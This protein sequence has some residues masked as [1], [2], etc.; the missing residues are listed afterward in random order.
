MAEGE[1][2]VL[3]FVGAPAA[4]KTEAAS[5]AMEMGIPVITMGDVI[6]GELR[7]RGL[8]LSDENAGRIANE[9]R[10]REGMDAIAKRCIPLIKGVKDVEEKKA[11]KV[12]VIDGIRGIAEVETFKKE[13]GTDFVLVRIDAPLILRYERIK[14]RGRGDDLL[15]IEE[16]KERE[17]RE[18]RWGMG[19]AMKKADKVVENEGSLE[20]FKEEI[21]RILDFKY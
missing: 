20:E 10:A 13:F 9:L 17:E 3:A 5:V 6:R 16:F 19:E 7:R 15:S 11:K 14:T 1:T 21:K 4:G 18:N 12:I 8:P 2:Q